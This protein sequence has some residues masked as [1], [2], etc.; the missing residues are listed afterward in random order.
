MWNLLSPSTDSWMDA[1][2]ANKRSSSRMGQSSPPC[3]TGLSGPTS[4]T[5]CNASKSVSHS[6]DGL[7]VRVESFV[8]FTSDL[9]SW[10]FCDGYYQNGQAA[11]TGCGGG[12]TSDMD[13]KA[14]FAG[15]AGVGAAV[16]TIV[17]PQS[18]APSPP[19]TRQ[20]GQSADIRLALTP[21]TT[22]GTYRFSF[23]LTVDGARVPFAALT[24]D[25]LLGPA[26]KWTGAACA[27][28]AMQSQIPAG[29]L[30][31]Y[32]CPES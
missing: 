7:T 19:L 9:N 20:P 28:P 8:P 16:P 4:V 10:Q 2:R 6:I 11:G 22:L 25:L 5:V 15:S 27:T 26:R 29:S 13:L 21:P 1:S 3:M 24:D 31:A 14:V 18:I 12:A 17:D 23:S 32:I 30:D